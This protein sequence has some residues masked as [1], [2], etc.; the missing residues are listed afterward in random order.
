MMFLGLQSERDMLQVLD[1]YDDP[2]GEILKQVHPTL[3]NVP[4][5][6]KSAEYVPEMEGVPDRE[7]ALVRHQGGGRKLRKFACV[8]PGNTAL[9]VTYFLYTHPTLPSDERQK[10]AAALSRECRRHK[11][12]VPE[13]LEKL[14]LVEEVAEKK[15][16]PVPEVERPSTREEKWLGA[17]LAEAEEGSDKERGWH[18]EEVGPPGQQDADQGSSRV[19]R[20]LGSGLPGEGRYPIGGETVEELTD[21]AKLA[22]AYFDEWESQFHPRERHTF[23]SRLL[24]ELKAVGLPLSE[25]LLKYASSER[26]PNFLLLAHSRRL[27]LKEEERPVLEAV[28]EKVAGMAPEEAA[29]TLCLFDGAMGLQHLWGRVPDP[30]QTVFHLEKAAA[31]VFQIGDKT[32]TAEDLNDLAQKGKDE[33]SGVFDSDFVDRFVQEPVAA[34]QALPEP[35]KRVIAGMI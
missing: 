2:N 15:A 25:T 3:A 18:K 35:T 31:P 6:I 5:L 23:C 10:V 20:L 34:F 32:L 27:F 17:F 12:G 11:L 19:R 21:R 22:S 8:D 13:F 33:L 1:V 9:S 16:P 7:F 29:E 14:A 4:D 28:I 26:G 30:W 24:P